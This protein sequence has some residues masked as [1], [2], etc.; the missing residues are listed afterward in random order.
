MCCCATSG[1]REPRCC[2]RTANTCAPDPTQRSLASEHR[3]LPPASAARTRACM[4]RRQARVRGIERTCWA[5]SR[6]SRGRPWA[7]ARSAIAICT[8]ATSRLSAPS[9]SRFTSSARVHS[10]STRASCTPAPPP[11]T[12]IPIPPLSSASRADIQSACC[13]EVMGRVR[14]GE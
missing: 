11:H 1:W 14:E 8:S 6:A 3:A 10:S 9:A 12:H 4:Q 2:F 5:R 7:M 13:M